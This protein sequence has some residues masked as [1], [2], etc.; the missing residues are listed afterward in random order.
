MAY[1]SA[2]VAVSLRPSSPFSIG[3]YR[4]LCYDELKPADSTICTTTIADMLEP[5]KN[6]LFFV[7]II[8]MHARSNGSNTQKQEQKAAKEKRRDILITRAAV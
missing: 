8:A 7:A 2:P 1:A 3:F 6:V 4:H 5:S